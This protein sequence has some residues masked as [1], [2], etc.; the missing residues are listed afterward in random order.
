MKL[1]DNL[2]LARCIHLG[3]QHQHVVVQEQTHQQVFADVALVP[4][5]ALHIAADRKLVGSYE[6]FLQLLLSMSSQWVSILYIYFVS[7][8]LVRLF[9]IL[10]RL[11]LTASRVCAALWCSP[12]KELL[13]QLLDMKLPL[14]TEDDFE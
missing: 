7:A 6:L 13:Q 14:Q 9:S 11:L 5:K 1:E 4:Q 10:H 2:L 8:V 12:S 3:L